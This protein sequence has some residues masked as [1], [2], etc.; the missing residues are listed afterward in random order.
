MFVRKP[1]PPAVR[2]KIVVWGLMGA[3]PIGG[4]VWQVLHHVVALRALGF[5]VWY[6]EDSDRPLYDLTTWEP[7][8][9]APQQNIDRIGRF[10]GEVGLGDRWAFRLPSTTTVVGA[11]DWTGLNRLYSETVA[12]LN[13]CGVQDL[14]D[15]HMAIPKR[16][17]L[18]TDPVGLQVNVAHGDAKSIEALH[19]HNW[20]FTYGVRLGA[21]DCPVPYRF[22]WRPTVPPVFLDF[23]ETN[24]LAADAP[25]STVL[26]W[27]HNDRD[28][29]WKGETWHWSKHLQFQ[30]F[31]DLPRQSPLPLELCLGGATDAERA[32]L[33]AHGWSLK[34]STE[35][36]EPDVYRDYIRASRGEFSVAKELVV[37]SRSGWVSDRTVCYLAAGRPAVVQDTGIGDFL[38]VG[39]GLFTFATSE[40]ALAAIGEIAKDYERQSAAAKRIA[41]EHFDAERVLGDIMRSAGVL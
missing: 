16:I 32:E 24:G 27:K 4:L 34:R 14:A 25:L 5:D 18:Q 8:R 7:Q 33:A 6:V 20:Y 11:L 3:L 28:V 12:A 22:P 40:E 23:W 41:R 38:P 39:E 15:R 37:I 36:L 21:P 2:G 26:N 35:Y 17:Y 31:I 30:R 10:L 19:R 29:E 13:L 1:Y 9:E